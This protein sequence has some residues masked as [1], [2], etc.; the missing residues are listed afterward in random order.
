MSAEKDDGKHR[1]LSGHL[2]RVIT[3]GYQKADQRGRYT[4]AERQQNL[5]D[6]LRDLGGEA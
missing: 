5:D 6:F 3:R 4:D 1:V 2:H